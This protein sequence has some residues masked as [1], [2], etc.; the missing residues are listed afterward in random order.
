MKASEAKS[1]TLNQQKSAGKYC[2]PHL[3]EEPKDFNLNKYKF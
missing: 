2:K 1:G 3:P